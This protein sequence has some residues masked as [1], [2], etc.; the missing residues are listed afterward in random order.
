MSALHR[1]VIAL[2]RDALQRD[3]RGKHLIE[4]AQRLSSNDASVVYSVINLKLL[5]GR[6]CLV[7]KD[8]VRIPFFKRDGHRIAQIAQ[9]PLKGLDPFAYFGLA[10]RRT[11]IK[12]FLQPGVA[13]ETL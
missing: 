4:L 9:R 3:G 13:L 6:E 1:A 8:S 5:Y 7:S 12:C 11:V 10:H 2:E